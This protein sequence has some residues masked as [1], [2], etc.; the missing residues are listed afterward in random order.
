MHFLFLDLYVN[1]NCY[2]VCV[3]HFTFISAGTNVTYTIQRDD[4]LLST[5]SV[6]RGIVPH[7]VTVTLG[8]M[9]QLGTGCHQLILNASNMVTYSEVSTNLQVNEH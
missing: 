3:F 8:V 7:N 6:E 1:F 4:M 5:V 9:K 2:F